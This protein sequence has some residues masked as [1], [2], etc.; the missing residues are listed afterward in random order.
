M[1]PADTLWSAY[2]RLGLHSWLE[3]HLALCL[4]LDLSSLVLELHLA[5]CLNLDL[6]S[7]GLSYLCCCWNLHLN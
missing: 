4:D 7:L 6:G 2:L 5:L 3:L 1:S